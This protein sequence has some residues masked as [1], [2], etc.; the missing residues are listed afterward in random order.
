MKF[1]K[2]AAGL[3]LLALMATPLMTPIASAIDVSVSG[4]IRQDMSWKL[5]NDDNYVNRGGNPL[6]GVPIITSGALAPGVDITKVDK[7]TDNDWNVFATKAEL[8]FD[9]SIRVKTATGR[10][11]TLITLVL[12]TSATAKRPT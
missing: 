3:P 8:D 6:N 5:T 10:V 4:F 2:K 11:M 7:S 12:K 1:S 9:I